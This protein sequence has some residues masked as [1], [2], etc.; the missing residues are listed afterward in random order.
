M[1]ARVPALAIGFSLFALGASAASP[2]QDFIDR[3]AKTTPGAHVAPAMQY[4]VLKSGPAT[5]HSPTRTSAVQAPRA[6]RLKPIAR[7]GTR[8]VMAA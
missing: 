2:Q 1:T 3:Y 4:R 8:A 6:N 5:G 7:A